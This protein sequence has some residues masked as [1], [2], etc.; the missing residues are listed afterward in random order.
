MFCAE[1]YCTINEVRNSVSDFSWRPKENQRLTISDAFEAFVLDAI[2]DRDA[3]RLCSP[4]GRIFKIEDSI[5]D[6]FEIDES[7]ERL[8]FQHSTFA[9]ISSESYIQK[10]LGAFE[11]SWQATIGRWTRFPMYFER[12]HYTIS[13]QA[14]RRYKEVAL[15]MLAENEL[16]NV[17]SLRFDEDPFWAVVERFEGYA[18]CAVSEKMPQ[19]LS[20][21][22]GIEM[23]LAVNRKGGRPSKQQGLCEFYKIHFP[24]GHETWKQVQK[25]Y[26]ELHGENISIDTFRRALGYRKN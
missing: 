12:E 9:D 13:L 19:T 24:N 3:L 25:K 20:N 22:V 1:G 2:L 18:L 6:W 11:N 16:F 15:T 7:L 8:V 21:T 26:F 17:L 14:L 4:E 5:V 10:T 23:Q